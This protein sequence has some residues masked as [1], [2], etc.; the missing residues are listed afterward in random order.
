MF[1]FVKNLFGKSNLYTC[2]HCGRIDSPKLYNYNTINELG[3]KKIGGKWVCRQCLNFKAENPSQI[4]HYNL[5]VQH[6][7]KRFGL[8]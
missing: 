2:T 4:L 1:N 3:W 8:V 7:M 5:V 6:K